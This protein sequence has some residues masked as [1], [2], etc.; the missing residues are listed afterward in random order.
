[1]DYER[2]V[3]DPLFRWFVGIGH[4]RADLGPDGLQRDRDRLPNQ[5]IPRS[6]FRRVVDW[7]Q[8]LM[9]D[10][11]F[12]VDGTL[13]E[14]SASQKSFQR[15]ELQRIRTLV[16]RVVHQTW[17]DCW[18]RAD[19]VLSLFEPHTTT[20]RKGAI[21]K[22]NEFGNWVRIRNGI[23]KPSGPTRWAEWRR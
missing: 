10:E 3:Y 14:S 5:K 23:T 20:I 7:A 1:M 15:K 18:A 19:R 21:S 13:I 22:R 17:H 11:H 9:S 8:S 12:T 4:G 2:A 16:E 6:L